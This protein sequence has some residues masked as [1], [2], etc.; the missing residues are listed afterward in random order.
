M[1]DRGCDSW[2][3]PSKADLVE[4]VLAAS[5]GAPGSTT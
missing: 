1:I 5:A 2:S 3:D 4:V